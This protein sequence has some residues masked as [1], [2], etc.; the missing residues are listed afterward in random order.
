MSVSEKIR[1]LARDGF[2]TTEIVRQ[3]G[4][5]YAAIEG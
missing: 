4:I 3:L 5:R 2:R 1:A